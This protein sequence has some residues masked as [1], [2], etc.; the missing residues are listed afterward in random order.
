MYLLLDLSDKKGYQDTLWHVSAKKFPILVLI[1]NSYIGFLLHTPLTLK[2]DG[3]AWLKWDFRSPFWWSRSWHRPS[4]PENLWSGVYIGT[5]AA[6]Q[7]DTVS[8]TLQHVIGHLQQCRSFVF[9]WF[10]QCIEITLFHSKQTLYADTK[11][12]MEDW[13]GIFVFLEQNSCL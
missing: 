3:Q 10:Q 5:A 4:L 2:A 7:R 6:C 1:L 8:Y 9:Q 11:N 12:K 13:S